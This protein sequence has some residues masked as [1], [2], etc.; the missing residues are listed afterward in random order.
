MIDSNEEL[1]DNMECLLDKFYKDQQKKDEAEIQMVIN[2]AY[3]IKGRKSG[4]IELEGL[5]EEKLI[6]KVNRM[7]QSMKRL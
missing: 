5:N 1:S 6:D 3:K 2:A 7:N 4:G